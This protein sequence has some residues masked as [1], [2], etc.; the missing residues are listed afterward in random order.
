[1]GGPHPWLSKSLRAQASCMTCICGFP[2]E[3]PGPAVTSWGLRLAWNLTPWPYTPTLGAPD[4]PGSREPRVHL[5]CLRLETRWP[6]AQPSR[7]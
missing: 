1:M 3:A 7:Q 6:T 2:G 5:M 4:V